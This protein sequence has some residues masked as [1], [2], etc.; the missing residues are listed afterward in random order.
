M[1][2]LAQV[3][4]DVMLVGLPSRVP[5][6]TRV[7]ADRVPQS[8]PLGGLDAA[9]AAARDE[10]LLLV[11]CDMPFVTARLFAHLLGQTAGV[12][13]VVPRTERG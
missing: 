9:L 13:A 11:A 4:D 7:V 3:T 5:A 2:A 12:D 6:G 1:A 8:G 10:A